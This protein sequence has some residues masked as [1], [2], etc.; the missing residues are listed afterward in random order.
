MA[1]WK[2][3]KSPQYMQ[4]TWW[5]TVATQYTGL[6]KL[7]LQP[8][9]VMDDQHLLQQTE[10]SH[11]SFISCYQCM[12]CFWI[13]SLLYNNSNFAKF[14]GLF[15]LHRMFFSISS[16][17]DCI[18]LSH[19]I[20]SRCHGKGVACRCSVWY[21]ACKSLVWHCCHHYWASQSKSRFRTGES[22]HWHYGSPLNSTNWKIESTDLNIFA[23]HKKCGM[24]SIASQYEQF[25]V[26]FIFISNIFYCN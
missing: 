22:G 25:G 5:Q 7:S 11:I 6:T 24:S 14:Y 1:L 8:H 19:Q 12:M 23:P 9:H 20:A 13:Y 16:L 17:T 4:R 18:F 21:A 2:W 10:V 26:S 15:S 3:A